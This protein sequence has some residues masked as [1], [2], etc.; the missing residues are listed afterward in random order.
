VTSNL[1][2]ARETCDSLAVPV[3][4]MSWSISIHFTQFTFEI[5][6]TKNLKSPILGVQGH[7]R[8]L[9]LTNLKSSSVPSC[10]RIHTIRANSGKITSFKGVPLFDAF[11]WEEASPRGA[12][13]CHEKLRTLGPPMVKILW[14]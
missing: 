3:R 12:K 9:M 14:S 5:C 2:K 13:F 10:N 7:L 1:S 4:M 8:S 11:V 6:V